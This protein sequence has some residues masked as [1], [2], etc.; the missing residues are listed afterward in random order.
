MN[1]LL[2]IFVA[3]VAMAQLFP[4]CG[5]TFSVMRK[6]DVKNGLSDN[7]VRSILQ[8]ST[9]YV[10]LG[11][12][13]GVN[14]FNGSEFTK[15]TIPT[16]PS[17][18][19][20]LNVLKLCPHID[21]NSIWVATTDGLYLFSPQSNQFTLFEKKTEQ[22]I[23]VE[24][25]VNDLCYDDDGLL[26]IATSKGLFAYNE[27]NGQ[28]RRYVKSEIDPSSLLDN[29]VISVF[30]D[31]SGT[32]WVGTRLGL[33]RYKR[34]SDSFIVYRLPHLTKLSHPFDV[35]T[36]METADGEIWVGTKYDG[37]LHLDKS[38]GSFTVYP[39]AT[40]HQDNTWI[41]ALFQYS[42]NIFFIG[43]EDGLFLFKPKDKTLQKLEPFNSKS[44]YSFSR[45]REG[46][47]W[48]GT[49]FDGVYYISPQSDYI[50]WFHD[51]GKP[52]SL[53]GNA[54]SQFCEDPDGNLWIATENGG[55][56][57]FNTQTE[58]FTRYTA[59][60]SPSNISYNNIHALM[61]DDEQAVVDWYFLQGH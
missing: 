21:K 7:T 54:V 24:R 31:S 27:K 6:Y 29:H 53:S 28:L 26:W 42:P 16:N 57:Y 11:T 22:G 32:L 8:D 60:G 37:L 45:D 39:V 49:Y 38:D 14:R 10:W 33:A 25:S 9:G 17:N 44:V 48:V 36:I 41:R 59:N 5:Q 40:G 19:M 2:R 43:T 35:S 52:N 61:L 3:V 4:L 23:C 50:K 1:Y 18:N 30:K 20:L 12:K 34:S 58:T 55:L 15:F 47:V 56:N 13:D 46:G 51:N